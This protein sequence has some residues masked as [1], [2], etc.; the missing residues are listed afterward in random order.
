MASIDC[1]LDCH[2][3]TAREKNIYIEFGAVDLVSDVLLDICHI[4]LVEYLPLGATVLFS[5]QPHVY[6]VYILILGSK[7]ITGLWSSGMDD[8][9]AMTNLV[10]RASLRRSPVR[11]RAAPLFVLFLNLIPV[12]I[13]RL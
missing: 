11:S 1:V 8:A 13:G 7:T 12:Q 2:K 4:I 9:F 5:L 3:V 10:V 6:C